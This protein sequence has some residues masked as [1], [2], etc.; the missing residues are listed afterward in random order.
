MVRRLS[1]GRRD[2]FDERCA[3][4]HETDTHY[5]LCMRKMDPAKARCSQCMSGNHDLVPKPQTTGT[6]PP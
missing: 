4:D 6:T 1:I 5:C 2:P 3:C